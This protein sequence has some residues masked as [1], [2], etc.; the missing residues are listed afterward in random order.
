MASGMIS[1]S[2]CNGER[3]RKGPV[4]AG[5]GCRGFCR[6]GLLA[7]PYGLAELYFQTS[8]PATVATSQRCSLEDQLFTVDAGGRSCGTP[9]L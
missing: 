2:N 8:A 1:H 9:V 3:T 5:M 6:A 4:P 7:Q